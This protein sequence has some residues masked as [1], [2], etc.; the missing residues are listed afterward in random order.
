VYKKI[1]YK[2][3]KIMEYNENSLIQKYFDGELSDEV[4]KELEEL[5]Q[6]N[7]ALRKKMSD[8][9]NFLIYLDELELNNFKEENSDFFEEIEAPKVKE[10][11]KSYQSFFQK[12]KK[13]IF[14]TAASIVLCVSVGIIYY[15]NQNNKDKSLVKNIKLN[16]KNQTDKLPLN[17]KN[18]TDKLLVVND[19]LKNI[20]P[21]K[22]EL[23]T[24][25]KPKIDY[26]ASIDENLRK[27]IKGESGQRGENNKFQLYEP[28][29]EIIVKDSIRFKWKG[30]LEK[31]ILI[32][33]IVNK[34][35]K[36]ITQ[37]SL[38]NNENIYLGDLE[39]G[40]FAFKIRDK[41]EKKLYTGY[42]IVEKK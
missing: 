35:D 9:K 2:I 8:Y 13:T 18:Q 5:A 27:E 30:T 37:F 7:P 4:E 36:F 22:E 17:T 21:K 34:F 33:E 15:L 25:E 11:K 3:K 16:T 23:K 28:K 10:V 29:N 41:S 19:S 26:L 31:E 38:K 40:F 12:N 14:T 1:N 6:N 20:I 42:F 39:E 32:I 24:I